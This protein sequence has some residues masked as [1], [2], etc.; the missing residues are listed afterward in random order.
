MIAPMMFNTKPGADHVADLHVAG[1]I[2][3]CVGRRADGHHEGQAVR[4]RCRDH[5]QCRIHAVGFGGRCQD[6]HQD[7]R[8][9]RVAGEF[10][11]KRYGK[12]ERGNDRDGRP[13]A[14]TARQIAN[15]L[16]QAGGFKRCR[17]ADAAAE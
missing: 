6:R 10:G 17:E 14:E 2:G 4:E 8:G 7:I 11:E 5:Q 13:I 3:D 16:R 1:A 15:D 12:A 9:G